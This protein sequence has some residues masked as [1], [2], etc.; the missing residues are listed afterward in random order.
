MSREIWFKSDPID[1]PAELFIARQPPAVASALRELVDTLA[2]GGVCDP[3][4]C[5]SDGPEAWMLEVRDGD[6]DGSVS[7]FHCYSS[8]G[9]R[10]GTGIE[11]RSAASVLPPPRIQPTEP[12]DVF[13]ARR[14]GQ[15][16]RATDYLATFSVDERERWR[17]VL[18]AM[19]R[20]EPIDPALARPTAE[21]RWL[22][23]LPTYTGLREWMSAS[24][25]DHDPSWSPPRW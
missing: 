11:A 4:L 23:Y 22:L 25:L 2:A 12:R 16:E 13:I 24:V 7:F 8:E 10:E 17:P 15:W 21:D 1:V 14:P 20:G 18:H 9:V 19:L 3:D 5:T 6:G